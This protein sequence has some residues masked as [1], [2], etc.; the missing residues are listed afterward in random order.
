MSARRAVVVGA[1]ALVVCGRAAAITPD[2][3]RC[4]RSVDQRRV[5]R[6]EFI[7]AEGPHHDSFVVYEHGTGKIPVD[8]IDQHEIAAAGDRP[9]EFVSRWRGRGPDGTGGDYVMTS[10]GA[11]VSG[12]SYVRKRDGK[13]V[14]FAVDDAAAGADGCD[15]QR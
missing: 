5:I 4:F 1:L 11:I 3:F 7:V 2:D 9:G 8:L 15:W 10:Q 14:R 6:L 12:F 13:I